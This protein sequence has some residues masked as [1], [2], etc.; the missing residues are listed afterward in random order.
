VTSDPDLEAEVRFSPRLF[1]DGSFLGGGVCPVE[2]G[3]LWRG[4]VG[5]CLACPGDGGEGE[6]GLCITCLC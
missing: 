3:A 1:L 5:L 2:G 6:G 4:V